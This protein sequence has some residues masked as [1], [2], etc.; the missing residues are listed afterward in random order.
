MFV[1]A[2]KKKKWSSYRQRAKRKNIPFRLPEHIFYA[3]LHTQCYICG[4][5]GT[6]N[7]LGM[8]RI[9]NDHGYI[10]GNIAPCCWECNKAKGSLGGL[11]FLQWLKR[12]Q[13]KHPLVTKG[14]C[15]P[16]GVFNGSYV[17]IDVHI[18]EHLLNQLHGTAKDSK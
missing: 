16:T 11:Q 2:E 12:L 1:S 8:D 4:K 7:E 13:P 15:Q 9:N 3:V 18:K 6:N 5:N 10:I 14:H 17:R